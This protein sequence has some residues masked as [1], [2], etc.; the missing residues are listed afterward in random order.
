MLQQYDL[1]SANL[2]MRCEAPEEMPAAGQLLR[3]RQ[4]L[5]AQSPSLLV[6]V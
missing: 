1:L 4:S 5:A 3:D 2:A 6:I